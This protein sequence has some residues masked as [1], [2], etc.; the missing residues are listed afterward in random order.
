MQIR[1]EHAKLENKM[2]LGEN[3]YLFQFDY[4]SL[5]TQW[6][7]GYHFDKGTFGPD[8]TESCNLRYGP[9]SNS[10]RI[11]VQRVREEQVESQSM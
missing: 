4:K 9:T 6:H 1:S 2:S 5:G 7:S 8:W 11:I 10:F 3:T